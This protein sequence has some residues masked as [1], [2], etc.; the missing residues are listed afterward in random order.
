MPETFLYTGISYRYL[1]YAGL[2]FNPPRLLLR[3]DLAPMLLFALI[4]LS[5]DRRIYNL[6][7]RIACSL[8][9]FGEHLGDIL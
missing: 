5:P 8:S 2:T 9:F 7:L 3:S 1:A 6:S 4:V